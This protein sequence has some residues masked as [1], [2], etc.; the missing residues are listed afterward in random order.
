MLLPYT[1]AKQYN[2]LYAQHIIF[3]SPETNLQAL[4]EIARYGIQAPIQK[5]TSAQFAE[6]LN[7]YYDQNNINNINIDLADNID[8]SK[9]VEDIPV[10]EDLLEQENDAPIIRMINT[11]LTQAVRDRASDI[12]IE[13][14]EIKSSVRF[15]V[16]GVLVNIVNIPNTLH[17]MLV[18]RIKIMADLDIAE[19]RQPQD[20][21]IGIKLIGKNIDI[22]LSTLPSAY[23]EH[24]VMRLLERNL[25]NLNL[26]NLGMREENLDK[27]KQ[28]LT[29]PYGI[30]LITGPTGSGK[31]T[32]LYAGIRNLN[33]EELN[34]LTAEDPIE[35]ELPNI[36]QTQINNKIDLTFAKVL[37]SILRQDPDIIM[38]GE[39]R[40]LETAQI[41]IQAALTG[42]LVLATLH[43]NNATSA[44]TRLID[45][46]IEPFL[47]SSTLSGVLAQRLVRKLCQCKEFKQGAYQNMGCPLCNKSGFLGRT[48][49]HELLI[50]DDNLRTSIHNNMPELEMQNY[51][52]KH[53]ML[54]IRQDA[55][56]LIEQGIT[57]IQEVER[58]CK[59]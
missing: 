33:A 58:V 1:F 8:L 59:E 2:I 42:H 53:G 26:T 13:A 15:R 24:V 7:I 16:D 6:K 45:M 3:I 55:Q 29:L 11:L 40:D 44:I 27:F 21:R 4:S 48:G 39:I 23:G 49:I 46:G 36:S 25:Q 56:R 18:S 17:N 10:V 57:T 34:I 28:L 12:H 20:G 51:A 22:R 50:I 54:S 41:A 35:Y 52:K 14:G 5:V 47:L 19:K 38:I 37:R 30:I 32:S 9:L 31:T 43:T